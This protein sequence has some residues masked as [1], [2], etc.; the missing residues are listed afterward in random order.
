MKNNPNE[1]CKLIDEAINE[2]RKKNCNIDMH[3]VEF[4]LGQE[5]LSMKSLNGNI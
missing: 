1:A 4:N 3:I 2:S 5:T